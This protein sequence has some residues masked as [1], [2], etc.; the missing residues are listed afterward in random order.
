MRLT[1]AVTYSRCGKSVRWLWAPVQPEGLLLTAK[2]VS[3][4]R[5][6]VAKCERLSG[7]LTTLPG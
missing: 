7:L 6:S 5:L 2:I 3:V 4:T 1:A